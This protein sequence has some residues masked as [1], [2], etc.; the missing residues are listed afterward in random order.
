MEYEEGWLLGQIKRA[1]QEI[2]EWSPSQCETF[3]L[4]IPKDSNYV[5]KEDI[6]QAAQLFVE[7]GNNLQAEVNLIK[8]VKRYNL[9]NP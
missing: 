7:F 3:G 8:A 2:R 4:P 6:L 1:T 9:Y 5:M